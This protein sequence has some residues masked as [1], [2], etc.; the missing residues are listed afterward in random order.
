MDERAGGRC[1]STG[2]THRY[3]MLTPLPPPRVPRRRT[4]LSFPA[5]VAAGVWCSGCV[6]FEN[7]YACFRDPTC[8]SAETA[9][10][11]DGDSMSG[12]PGTGGRS[13][14][15]GD[16][17]GDGDATASGGKMLG[18]GG[19]HGAGGRRPDS[20]G[21]YGSDDAS[22][23]QDASGGDDSGGTSSG[24]GGS[25]AGGETG[26]GGAGGS[27]RLVIN[28]MRLNPS[29]FIEI[30]NASNQTLDLTHFAVT[31]GTDDPNWASACV[32]SGTLAPGACL[33]VTSGSECRGQAICIKDCAWTLSAGDRAYVLYA[34]EQTFDEV[35]D[36]R[37][38]PT[39]VTIAIGQSYSATT[40]GSST[41][42]PRDQSPGT[43]N[44]QE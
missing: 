21:G 34:E 31:T 9:F 25:P 29:G 40:D 44:A 20:A 37:S 36:D 27:T 16:G 18:G 3:K 35:L 41:F 22:G 32:L 10:T 42:A 1:R 23:G 12:A 28:E 15:S 13:P 11:G 4:S 24:G 33:E 30:Y 2:T 6:F 17:D 38:Y 43:T 5:L 39:N 19:V 7:Q 26:A 8:S 14:D